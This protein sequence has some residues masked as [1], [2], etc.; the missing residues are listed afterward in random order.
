MRS[1]CFVFS[2]VHMP[3]FMIMTMQPIWD[4][5]SEFTDNASKALD[6]EATFITLGKSKSE[7]GL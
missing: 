4:L 3:M 2:T 5:T 7:Y 6:V 1:V